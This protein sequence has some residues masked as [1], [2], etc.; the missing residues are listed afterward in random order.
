[1]FGQLGVNAVDVAAGQVDFVQRDDDGDVGRLGVMYGFDGL[2][3][4]A[5]V[6]GDDQHD[7]VGHIG[8]SCPHSR[9][10]LVARGIEECNLALADVYLVCADVLGDSACFAWR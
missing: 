2:R 3:H 9:K 4:Y 8:A 10:C 7:D 1:M 5:V 6:G